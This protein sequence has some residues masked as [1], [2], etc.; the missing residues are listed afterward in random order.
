MPLVTLKINNAMTVIITAGIHPLN[1]NARIPAERS[2]G[3]TLAPTEMAA[4][5]KECSKIISK[6]LPRVWL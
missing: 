6:I 1:T 5:L 2:V 3:K 4:L